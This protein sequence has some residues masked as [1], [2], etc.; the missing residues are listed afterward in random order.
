LPLCCPSQRP[1]DRRLHRRHRQRKSQGEIR[2]VAIV[3]SVKR[4]T[5]L[6]LT[7]RDCFSGGGLLSRLPLLA[8]VSLM[9]IGLR[10]RLRLVSVAGPP[11][12]R[13]LGMNWTDELPPNASDCEG[14]SD[15]APST[16]FCE[17]AIMGDCI[18]DGSMTAKLALAH[19]INY[20]A[21]STRPRDGSECDD[22]LPYSDM[23][24]SLRLTEE[25]IACA[26]GKSVGDY[27]TPSNAVMR[28]SLC[29]RECHVQPYPQAS[30]YAN[31]CVEAL[32]VCSYV[33]RAVAVSHLISHASVLLAPKR[34]TSRTPCYQKAPFFRTR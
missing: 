5:R 14:I 19:G 7:I 1:S 22:G 18:G 25:E 17:G 6:E 15:V 4:D 31:N 11:A 28:P 9:G 24:M 8:D 29:P 3:E 16:L 34:S 33:E 26:L 10:L 32:C 12:T 20:W 27:L 30:A 2:S 21:T 23:R 13:T